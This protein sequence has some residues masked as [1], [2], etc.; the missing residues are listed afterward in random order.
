MALTDLD[1]NRW[2]DVISIRP[3]GLKAWVQ[4]PNE[5]QLMH[6]ALKAVRQRQGW[7]RQ[8]GTAL[9]KSTPTHWLL[10]ECRDKSH[11]PILKWWIETGRH[12]NRQTTGDDVLA[13]GV[14]KGPKIAELLTIAQHVAWEGGSKKDEMTAIQTTVNK[15]P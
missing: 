7:K 12:H 8:A 4:F 9:Q 10:L 2:K 15:S 11:L 14:P 13:L 6:T 1:A 5:L 3:N